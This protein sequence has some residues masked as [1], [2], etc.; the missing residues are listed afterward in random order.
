MDR[1]KDEDEFQ[2]TCFYIKQ[3]ENTTKYQ[4]K[5]ARSSI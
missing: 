3:K 1:K 4:I 2:S 5:R